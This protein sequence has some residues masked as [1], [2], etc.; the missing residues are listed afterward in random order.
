[1]IHA[2]ICEAVLIVRLGLWCRAAFSFAGASRAKP[3]DAGKKGVHTVQD[4]YLVTSKKLDKFKTDT[5]WTSDTTG[6]KPFLLADLF[7]L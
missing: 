6:G 1:M 7:L 3:P 2:I 5:G 4:T